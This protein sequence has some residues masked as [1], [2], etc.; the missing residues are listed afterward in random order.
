MNIK[1]FQE[2]FQL[3]PRLLKFFDLYKQTIDVYT[4]TKIA[5]GKAPTFGISY[6]N[7]NEAMILNGANFSTKI[8]TSK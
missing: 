5:L 3:D 8:Y 2:L 4:R 1:D 7:A 6:S